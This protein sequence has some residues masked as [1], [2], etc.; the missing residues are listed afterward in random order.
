MRALF[1]FLSVASAQRLTVNF[2]VNSTYA[3]KGTNCNAPNAP[4]AFCPIINCEL[5]GNYCGPAWCSGECVRERDCPFTAG[6]TGCTDTCCMVHDKCCGCYGQ[7]PA[8]C[9]P[10]TGMG[11]QNCNRALIQCLNACGSD[12]SCVDQDDSDHILGPA[13]WPPVYISEAFSLFA[14][15]KC[16]G[17]DCPVSSP[18]RLPLCV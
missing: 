15:N 6:A 4:P 12:R 17:Q 16:C 7:D 13:V 8:T 5:C 1:L 2:T 14:A 10:D 3:A 11:Q 9:N 18:T